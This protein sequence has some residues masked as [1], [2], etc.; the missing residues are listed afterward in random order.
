MALLK[1]LIIVVYNSTEWV[2]KFKTSTGF[3]IYYWEQIHD[4]F[5]KCITLTYIV[6]K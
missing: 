5:I 6:I 4:N 3:T 1:I 2:G